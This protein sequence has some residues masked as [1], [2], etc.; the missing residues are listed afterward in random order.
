M[1]NYFNTLSLREKLAQL[2][3]CRFMDQSEF[4]DGVEKLRGKKLVVADLVPAPKPLPS[5]RA[6]ALRLHWRKRIADP[7]LLRSV[8]WEKP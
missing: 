1:A 8:K 4:A 7:V 6:A 3:K 5:G 2:G